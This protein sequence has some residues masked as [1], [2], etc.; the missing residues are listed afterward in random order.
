MAP[1][2]KK[3]LTENRLC[4]FCCYNNMKNSIAFHTS[5]RSKC[6]KQLLCPA[7]NKKV[8]CVLLYLLAGFREGATLRCSVGSYFARGWKGDAVFRGGSTRRSRGGGRAPLVK[9]LAP[10]GSPTAPSEVH[11]AGISLMCSLTFRVLSLHFEVFTVSAVWL[12]YVLISQWQ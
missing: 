4:E 7:L 5:S 11:V 8:Y 1:V 9:S 3:W 2:N 10:C 6:I 12:F